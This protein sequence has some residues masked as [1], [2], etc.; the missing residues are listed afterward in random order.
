[1]YTHPKVG[2]KIL[3]PL[4]TFDSISDWILYHHERI[5]GNGYYRLDG[6]DIP[7]AAKMIAIADTYSAITM[8]RSY[9]NSKTHEQAIAI[10]KDVEG[11]QLDRELVDIFAA[12]PKE[13]LEK[14]IPEHVDY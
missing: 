4:H 2:V 9:K 8:R 13:E 14:C 12:I 7:L 6:N 5:D 10:M 1:M 3:K 11:T